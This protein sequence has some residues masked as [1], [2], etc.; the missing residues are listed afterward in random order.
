MR[1]AADQGTRIDNISFVLMNDRE[2]LQYNRTY[3][4]HDDLTDVITFPT[5]SNNG[6]A[7]DI[8]ISLDRVRENAR[9]YGTSRANE[10]RRVMVHGL[11]HL[12]GHEDA[13]AQQRGAMRGLE[14]RLLLR[15]GPTRRRG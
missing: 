6:L 5:P 2:L 12:C 11:L 15:Y 14:D 8:L 4:R 1:A 13:T 3:L 10:L 9:R 7:G